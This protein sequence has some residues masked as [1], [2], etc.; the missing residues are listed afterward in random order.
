M[1]SLVFE[2][3]IWAHIGDHEPSIFTVWMY[4]GSR[5]PTSNHVKDLKNKKKLIFRGHQSSNW[6]QGLVICMTTRQVQWCNCQLQKTFLSQVICKIT[7]KTLT[8]DNYTHECRTGVIPLTFLI[9]RYLWFPK[10]PSKIPLDRENFSC[11]MQNNYQNFNQ[12]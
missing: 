2:G 9:G 5:S 10:M 6:A 1:F 7:I 11:Y 3:L 12:R 4:S 8:S